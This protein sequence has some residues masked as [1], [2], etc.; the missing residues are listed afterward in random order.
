MGSGFFYSKA[1]NTKE[2]VKKSRLRRAILCA[3]I[4]LITIPFS[5]KAQ[6]APTFD[7]AANQAFA[8]CNNGVLTLDP[9][10][11]VTDPD[12]GQTETYT[13]QTL[14]ANGT[15]TGPLGSVTTAG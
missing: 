12:A 11:N 1:S 7:S 3:G 13:V 15:I 10:M 5:G 4:A 8:I 2:N 6:T 9:Y 14:P